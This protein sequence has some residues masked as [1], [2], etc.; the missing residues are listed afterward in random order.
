MNNKK[1]AIIGLGLIGGSLARALNS[2]LNIK[3]IYAVNRSQNSID[4]AIKEGVIKNGFTEINQTITSC[5]IIFICT[6]ISKTI[7]YIHILKDKVNT[8]T[9]ITDVG[10]TKSEIVNFVNNLDFKLNFVGGHPMAGSESSGYKASYPHL[11]ENAFYI[12]TPGKYTSEKSIETLITLSKKIGAFP[13]VIDSNEHDRV[14][15]SISHLPHIAAASLVNLVKRTDKNN[16]MKELAVGGFKDITRISS[17]SPEIWES[18]ILS[19][20]TEIK[21]I[22][23]NYIKILNNFLDYIDKNHI[24]SIY[25]FFSEAKDY[26]DSFSNSKKTKLYPIL[27]IAIDVVDRPGVI[28]E[29]ATILGANNINIK[30]LNVSNSREYEEGCIKIT[31]SDHKSIDKS[32][33]LLTNEKFKV[34]YDSQKF[35]K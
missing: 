23:S 14:T 35:K 2:K 6:S 32:I 30:N 28:G 22:L 21:N 15:G 27:D 20:K 1:I 33:D 3:E 8:N 12:F 5:D 19:N 25:N 16:L 34:F 29:I 10:S 4:L 13:I 24:E 9:I 11:F 26:R 7:D 18:I 17:S 31:L